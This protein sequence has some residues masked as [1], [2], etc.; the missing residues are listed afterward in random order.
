MSPTKRNVEIIICVE[1]KAEVQELDDG[2][3]LTF[4]KGESLLIPASVSG[5][6]LGG[7]AK[8][9]KATVPK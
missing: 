1:G 2:A 6:R 5:Y 4:C 8:L 9:Y 3:T 7:Q